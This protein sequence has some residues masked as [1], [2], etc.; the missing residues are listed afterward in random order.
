MNM[1]SGDH[2]SHTGLEQSKKEKLA[3]LE[4][5]RTHIMTAVPLAIFSIFVMGWDILNQFSY[6]V[7]M[8][9]I[10]KEFFHHLLPIFATYILFV[11]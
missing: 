10:W 5:M 2:R 6:A 7:P 4:G 11:V 1:N 3:E 8:P 9:Y